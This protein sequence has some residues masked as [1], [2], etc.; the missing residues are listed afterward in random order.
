M[1]L[2]D[3]VLRALVRCAAWAVPRD[4][5]ARWAEEWRAD[6]HDLRAGGMS[7]GEGLRWVWGVGRG[8]GDMGLQ[9]GLMDGW[10]RE[11]RHALR[12][13][14][15]QPGF[16]VVAVATLGLGIGANTA[17]FSVVNGVV[18]EP[19]P[20]PD[21]EELVAINSAFPTMGFETFWVSPPEYLE[22]RERTRTFAQ[23][24]A[25]RGSPASVGGGERP[26]RVPGAVATAEL[27]EVLGVSARY[28]RTFGPDDDRPGAEPV[29]LMSW[30]LWQ[31]SFG[32]D[33]DLVGTSID[34]DGVNATVVGVMP[35]GFDLNDE[36]IELWEP[37]GL[38]PTNPGGRGSHYLNLVG[39]LARGT[40]IAA[41]E[42]EVD[43]L[44]RGWDEANPGDMHLPNPETHPFLIE[45]L[46]DRVVGPVR[47]ALWVLLGAVGFVLLIAC[48]NVANLLLARAEA[49]QKEVS[50]RVAL[51]AGRARLIRQFL[52]EGI[53]LAVAGGVVGVVF[54]W[55]SLEVLRSVGPDELPRLGEVELDGMVLLFT[56]AVALFT[57][58]LFG[59]APARHI[60]GER[61]SDSLRE[62]GT[63]T[64]LGGGAL[65]LRSLLVISEV[66]LALVLTLGSG[67]LIRSFGE[68][69]S[70]DPGFD[71]ADRVT[72]QLFLPA[73]GYGDPQD[74]PDFHGRLQDR[75]G[76]LPGVTSVASMSGL[77]PMRDLNANDTEFEGLEQREDGPAHN[78][79]YYQTVH[80]PY[81]ETM[82]IQ[83]VRG[84][85]F[86]AGD[87]TGTL[88]VAVVN[89]TL[90]RV[91]YGDD[92]P[93]GRR[94]RPC[95]GGDAWMEI[96]GVVEDVKQGGLDAETGTEVYFLAEQVAEIYGF[97]SR[98][99]N[100]VVETAG[101]PLSVVPEARRTVAEMD[102]T[103]PIAGLR[104]MDEVLAGARARPRFLT[105]LLGAFAGVALLLAAV[106][107]Y[108]VM[109]YTVAQR[110]RE[111][112]IRM[113]LGAEASSV[114]ALVMRRGLAVAGLGLG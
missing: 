103:L 113:A 66:A 25:Y 12:G 68:L 76:S 43:E 6:L 73:A 112:G 19:L 18:L 33:P 34:V 86:E 50:V 92:D 84:R 59:L 3:R 61:V 23:V 26:E 37:L 79:D 28:G 40:D 14:L 5:R 21:S 31:R 90:A 13:L 51:G 93:I 52:T 53:V 71:A 72:F 70:V 110:A 1:R 15:R 57:G 58:L 88:P 39:R 44:V 56:A 109:S 10:M 77:P 74:S 48:A 24:G 83:V 36:G 22:F 65:R 9:E 30:E 89:E 27:F 20:Y 108:G 16:T 35:P 105:T 38:D 107:T 41:A 104:T 47:S 99:M 75:L 46:H 95:C 45:P 55:T 60:G 4:E 42:R 2:G 94:I 101:N 62:G 69:V 81:L 80:G 85:G 87:R 102:P 49:R 63:R 96:V 91:F 7:F 29:V 67:L 98:S 64:T 111:M 11:M 54:A 32:A 82:G 100:V 17:I 8:A 106:G 114:Q 97:T 78:V